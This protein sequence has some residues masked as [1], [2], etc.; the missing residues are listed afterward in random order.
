MTVHL[1]KPNNYGCSIILITNMMLID[2]IWYYYCYDC[3]YCY[4]TGTT[5]DVLNIISLVNPSNPTIIS[6]R[7]FNDVTDG[8]PDALALCRFGLN[9]FLAISFEKLGTVMKGSVRFFRPLGG[10]G[11]P[12]QEIR[13]PVSSKGWFLCSP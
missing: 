11:E 10:P 13:D 4:H 6:T 3:E 8:F 1:M 2:S 9:E 12:L 7:N 5:G